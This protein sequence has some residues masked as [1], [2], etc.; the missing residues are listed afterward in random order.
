M[1]R[2]YK[3][4]L[5]ALLLAIAEEQNKEMKGTPMFSEARKAIVATVGAV[6]T[7]LV[8]FTDTFS[9]LSPTVSAVIAAVVAVGTGVVTY[10]TRNDVSG[11]IDK[12]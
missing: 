2:R 11:V 8:A 7:L 9:T 1:I 6:L 4:R 5:P 10:L 3:Q 12:Y